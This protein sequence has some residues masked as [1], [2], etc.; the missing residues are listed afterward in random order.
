MTDWNNYISHK[1]C[2]VALYGV[3][4]YVCKNCMAKSWY[5]TA[6]H[7][8][9]SEKDASQLIEG[10]IKEGGGG[11]LPNRTLDN[12]RDQPAPTHTGN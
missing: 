5:D 10:Q 12:T 2:N 8:G 1:L 6:I 9:M 3:A 4:G 7:Y 11:V